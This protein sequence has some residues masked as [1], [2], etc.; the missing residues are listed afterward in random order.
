MP[1]NQIPQ[2]PDLFAEATEVRPGSVPNLPADWL[3]ALGDEFQKAYWAR[4]QAFVDAEREQHDVFPAAS[5]VFTAFRLTP[6][7]SVRVLLLGQDPYPGEGQAHG[8]CFSQPAFGTASTAEHLPELESDAASYQATGISHEMSESKA[9]LLLN[10]LTVRLG[11]ANSIRTRDG[12][13]TGRDPP[14]VKPDPVVFVL[15]GRTHE[16][17]PDRLSQRVIDFKTA[18]TAFRIDQLFDWPLS[19]INLALEK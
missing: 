15:W 17:H 1:R 10:A 19:K 5:E 3:Q 16:N 8:L 9:S 7:D 14:K 18:L 11:G 12:S 13:P 2:Q 6:F 4:L